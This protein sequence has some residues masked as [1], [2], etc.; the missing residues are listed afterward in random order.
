[1]SE[2]PPR[3]PLETLHRV[4]RKNF[5]TRCTDFRRNH[6]NSRRNLAGDSKRVRHASI[7]CLSFCHTVHAFAR[8]CII[9]ICL[10]KKKK[11]KKNSRETHS[12]L[13]VYYWLVLL[14][15]SASRRHQEESHTI[16]RRDRSTFGNITRGML[17]NRSF[18]CRRNSNSKEKQATVTLILANAVRIRRSDDWIKRNFD[19]RS[20]TQYVSFHIPCDFLLYHVPCCICFNYSIM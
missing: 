9:E 1:M 14:V 5:R 8:V 6:R 13:S 17:C 15:V 19:M 4:T 18:F 3:R 2:G 12:C 7:F 16:S 11:K 10:R 20:T